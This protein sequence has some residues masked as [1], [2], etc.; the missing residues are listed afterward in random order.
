MTSKADEPIG[1]LAGFVQLTQTGQ[2]PP[3]SQV[4]RRTLIPVRLLLIQHAPAQAGS[5]AD[6]SIKPMVSD[7]PC[8]LFANVKLVLRSDNVGRS[9]VH[10][11]LIKKQPDNLVAA[12]QHCLRKAQCAP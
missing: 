6:D 10:A 9:T 3:C 1:L 2:L 12:R 8:P 4:R 11:I 5:N 7:E